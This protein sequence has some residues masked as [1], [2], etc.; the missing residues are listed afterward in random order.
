VRKLQ[1]IHF[2]RRIFGSHGGGTKPDR[3]ILRYI[4]LYKQKKIVLSNQITHRFALQNINLGAELMR[5]GKT[6]RCLI[7][8]L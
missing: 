6:V 4:N 3:D 5:S 7:E 1:S 8:M 2:R